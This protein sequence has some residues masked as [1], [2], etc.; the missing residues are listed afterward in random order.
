MVVSQSL[1]VANTLS[2]NQPHISQSLQE[3]DDHVEY[4]DG[5]DQDDDEH[6]DDAG[7]GLGDRQQRRDFQPHPIKKP[8]DDQRDDK[9]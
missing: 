1:S 5:S 4:D 2:V 3:R 7:E 9:L 6:V 8:A